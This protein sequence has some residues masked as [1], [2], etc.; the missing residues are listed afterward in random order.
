VISFFLFYRFAEAQLTKMVVP[1]LR[2]GFDKRRLGLTT[3]DIGIIYGTA[4]VIALMRGGLLGG[5]VINKKGLK[6]LAVAE[7][8]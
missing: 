7:W 1:F 5:Y 6:I 8:C 3:K 4:G 2:D